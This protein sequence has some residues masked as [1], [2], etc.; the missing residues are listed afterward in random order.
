MKIAISSR[1]TDLNA[2]VD[3]RFG[4]AACFLIVDTETNQV[5]VV[6]NAANVNAMQAAGVQT[7]QA[8]AAQGVRAVL[9]GHVGPKAF[10]ALR[11]AG[12][13]VYTGAAGTVREAVE[14]F[15]AGKLTAAAG[16]DVQG[17]GS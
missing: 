6:D 1:G 2:T 12:I 5:A 15:R 4:R 7:A 11:A 3:P 13:D 8:V 17:H 16:A 14:A 9:S 10:T